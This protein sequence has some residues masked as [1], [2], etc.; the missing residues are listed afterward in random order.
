M[1]RRLRQHIF[2]CPHCAV[3]A[4][5]HVQRQRCCRQSRWRPYSLRPAREPHRCPGT[6]NL[7]VTYNINNGL[8]ILPYAEPLRPPPYEQIANQESGVEADGRDSPPPAY[9]TID[10]RANLSVITEIEEEREGARRGQSRDDG[11]DAAA[12][13][14]RE[15]VSRGEG[16]GDRAGGADDDTQMAPPSYS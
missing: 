8:Q 12:A 2:S 3:H 16:S 14:R 7:L 13:A 4:G 6:T 15:S 5:Q 1:R 9:Q 10:R 11:D